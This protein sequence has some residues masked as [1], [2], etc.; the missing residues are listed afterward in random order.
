[1]RAPSSK[2]QWLV[3][4]GLGSLCAALFVA[5]VWQRTHSLPS[6]SAPLPNFFSVPD[7]AL[8]NQTGQV[9]TL[10]DL[11]GNLW[12]VDIIFTRCAGPCPDMTRRMAELQAQ[13][14]SEP[15]LRLITLTTDPGHDTPAVLAAYARRFGAEAGRWHF[16]TGTKP[17]I[18]ALA[19]EGLKLTAQDKDPAQQENP[20]DLF[21]HSSM[22]VLVDGEGRAR[23]IFESDDPEL[24][25]KTKLAVT[26]LLRERV[27]R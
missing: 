20:N 12:L 26:A 7:F 25:M 11:R 19:V 22:L 4:G 15:R 5:S 23:G 1:M 13:F 3:W 10:A 8:T 2:V 9:V 16:L 27:E 6:G 18:A 14:A 21:I 24:K 17:Q